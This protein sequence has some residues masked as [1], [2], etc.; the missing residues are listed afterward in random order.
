MNL[1]NLFGVHLKQSNSYTEQRETN[2]PQTWLV[3]ELKEETYRTGKS[4]EKQ[5]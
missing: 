5:N 3:A 4:P 1:S 2:L